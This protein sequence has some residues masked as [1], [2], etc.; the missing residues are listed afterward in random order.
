MIVETIPSW[1]VYRERLLNFSKLPLSVQRQW[2][3]RGHSSVT[4]DLAATVDRG[5]TI[6]D[7][8]ARE[9]KIEELLGE[10][11]REAMVV[12]GTSSLPEGDDLELLARHH[13]LPSPLL[14]WT[15]SPWIASFFA[16]FSADASKFPTIS[17][18]GL[19]RS[20]VDPAVLISTNPKMNPPIE[21]IDDSS[22][23]RLNRRALQQ[24]GVFLRVS[25]IAK[26]LP[27]I[28]G[29]ALC[30]FDLPASERDEVLADLDQ[31]LLN[32]TNLMYDLEGAAKT[33]LLR[34]K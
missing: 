34:V 32:P 18:Y 23:I 6:A 21:I 19:N 28:L 16:F 3:F 1:K 30:R 5:G 12:T 2:W 9:R 17:I 14:D 22:K 4:Y 11:R 26:P 24:R 29:N 25:T 33:A 7:D 31:M 13:G 15:L 10:F 8:Q 27:K 20:A